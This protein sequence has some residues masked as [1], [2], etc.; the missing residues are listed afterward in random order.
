MQLILKDE[1]IKPL[2]KEIVLEI[3]REDRKEFKE[4]FFEVLEEISLKNAINEGLK[5]DVVSEDELMKVLN[6][7]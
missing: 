3:L 2:L 7:D 6:G 1:N 4:I 5:S